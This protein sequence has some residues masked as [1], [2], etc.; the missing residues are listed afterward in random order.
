MYGSHNALNENQVV[1]LEL[2]TTAG[3]TMQ[4]MTFK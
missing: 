2:S 4:R 3:T 1:S